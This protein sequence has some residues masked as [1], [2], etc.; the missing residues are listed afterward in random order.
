MN[1]LIT[2]H[3]IDNM[4]IEAKLIEETDD[5]LEVEALNLSI[6]EPFKI[7]KT[8]IYRVDEK[9]TQNE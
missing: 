7:S 4:L 9:E 2:I 8:E 6:K 1:K 3:T 5:Y